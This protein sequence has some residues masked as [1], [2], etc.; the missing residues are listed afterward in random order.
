[1]FGG[2]FPLSSYIDR[3][4]A[5]FFSPSLSWQFEAVFHPCSRLQSAELG[6]TINATLGDF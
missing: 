3:A 5:E 2:P 1:M 4:A 6:T